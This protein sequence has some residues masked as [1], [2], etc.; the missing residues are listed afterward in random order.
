LNILA[1]YHRRNPE[2]E[3]SIKTIQDEFWNEYGRTFFTRYDYEH[4]ECEQAEKVVALLSEFVSRPNVCG[5]H[6][7]ADESFK[8]TDCGDFS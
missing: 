2:K 7:P 6:L 4:I 5:S 8:V 3:A 1:I